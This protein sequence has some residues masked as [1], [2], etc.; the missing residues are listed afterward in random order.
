MFACLFI[1][2]KFFIWTICQTKSGGIF[3]L[4]TSSVVTWIFPQ[5]KLRRN[6]DIPLENLIQRELMQT[7]AVQ[8]RKVIIKIGNGIRWLYI[9]RSHMKELNTSTPDRPHMAGILNR[10]IALKLWFI[11]YIQYDINDVMQ[12]E[13]MKCSY[14]IFKKYV[15]LLFCS[16]H[17]IFLNSSPSVNLNE[18]EEHNYLYKCWLYNLNTTVLSIPREVHYFSVVTNKMN[19]N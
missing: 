14:F 10:T 7:C 18:L 15:I 4:L 12:F 1:T 17:A 13:K 8:L 11:F 19:N 5:R 16:Q 3:H 2:C 9:R 6:F